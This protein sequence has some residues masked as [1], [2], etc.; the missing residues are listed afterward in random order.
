MNIQS[1]HKQV[2][3]VI[4]F[5]KETLKT[6]EQRLDLFNH[7]L[8]ENLFTNQF[9]NT[10]YKMKNSILIHDVFLILYKIQIYQYSMI[11]EQFIQLTSNVNSIIIPSETKIIPYSSNSTALTT[12]NLYQMI[13]VYSYFYILFVCYFKSHLLPFKLYYILQYHICPHHAK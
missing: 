10:L 12:D 9:L 11:D 6:T 2:D 8:D 4:L 7:Y 3:Y 5:K 13:I 1:I